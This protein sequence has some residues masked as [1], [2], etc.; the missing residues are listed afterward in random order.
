MFFKNLRYTDNFW[1]TKTP[2]L[3]QPNGVKP[4]LG[5]IVTSLDMHM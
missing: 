1:P 5:N 3:L 2:T 4:E